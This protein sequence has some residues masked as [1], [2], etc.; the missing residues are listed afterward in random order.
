MRK[1]MRQF[2]L[3]EPLA[4]IQVTRGVEGPGREVDDFPSRTA[5]LRGTKECEHTQNFFRLSYSE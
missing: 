2:T 1:L 4:V 3:R 5:D